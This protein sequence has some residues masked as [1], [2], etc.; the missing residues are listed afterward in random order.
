MECSSSVP[1][2]TTE[3]QAAIESAKEK[4]TLS[5]LQSAIAKA[6]KEQLVDASSIAEAKAQI[7]VVAKAELGVVMQGATNGSTGLREN[8][9]IKARYRGKSKY[10][11][12]RLL[13]ECGGGKWDIQYDDGDEEYGVS[14]ELIKIHDDGFSRSA[15]LQ[16]AIIKA[17]K[18]QLISGDDSIIAE[19]KALLS[20]MM[21]EELKAATER[22][23]EK[24]TL[25]TVS[26]THLTLPTILRV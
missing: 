18:E 26:Y 25:S 10:Y 22:A 19:A 9:N 12:G 7:P 11:P 21:K 14:E 6:E 4:K 5:I 15:F 1:R 20:S 17:E 3:L 8:M 24:K 2:P 13:R 23:I 16:S